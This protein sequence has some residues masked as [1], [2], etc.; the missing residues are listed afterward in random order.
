MKMAG[1]MGGERQTTLNLEVVDVDAE[2]NLLML[3][4]AVPGAKGA[5]VLVREA[6]KARG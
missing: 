4:G 6:V 3:R 5:V 1:R 2:R